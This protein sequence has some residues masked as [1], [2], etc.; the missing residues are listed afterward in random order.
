MEVAAGPKSE[1]KG[2]DID[3]T[4]EEEG[5]K[6]KK[7]PCFYTYMY[8]YSRLDLNVDLARST[9]RYMYYRSTGIQGALVKLPTM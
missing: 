1:M 2:G 7:I 3:K 6:K 5:T 9:G 8:A 4:Q